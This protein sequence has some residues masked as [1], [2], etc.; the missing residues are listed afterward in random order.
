MILI[1]NLIRILHDVS[2]DEGPP[3]NR[4]EADK[5][6]PSEMVS[7]PVF[8]GLMACMIQFLTGLQKMMPSSL[9]L[10]TE[11]CR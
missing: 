6:M 9:L 10:V 2:G 1:P 5:K 8:S 7:I 11:I 4:L 3:Q